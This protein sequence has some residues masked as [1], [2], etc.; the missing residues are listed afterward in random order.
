MMKNTDSVI[1]AY[2]ASQAVEDGVSVQFNPATALECGYALPVIL[3]RAAYA[4]AVEWT[5]RDDVQDADARFW[6]VLNMARRPA[7]AAMRDS[8]AHTFRVY[9]LANTTPSGRPSK[10]ETATLT[11]LTVRA[12]G[13]DL[14]GAPCLVIGTPDED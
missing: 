10:A 9:R 8:E 14:S 13:Y 2:T 12:E 3:T 6:D 4:D 7:Q 5:R 1:H 11:T